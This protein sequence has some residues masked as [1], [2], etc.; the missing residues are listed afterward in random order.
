[1]KFPAMLLF[2]CISGCV[3]VPVNIQG[4]NTNCGISSD[5][6]TLRVFNIAKETNTFYSIEG[7]VATPILLPTTAILSSIYVVANNIYNI[8]EQKLVCE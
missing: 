7:I 1:M 2:I 5:R 6:K 4:H 3:V 8:G